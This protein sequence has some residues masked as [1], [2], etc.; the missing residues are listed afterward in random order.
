MRLVKWGLFF[1]V[2]IAI[3][4]ISAIKWLESVTLTP[5]SL[6]QPVVLQVKAGDTMGTVV[7]KLSS[8]GILQHGEALWF[9]I[10]ITDTAQKIHVGEYQLEPGITPLAL[11]EKLTLGEVIVY[12][13]TVV[14]GMRF[15]DV[16]E[17]LVENSSVKSTLQG[18][19]EKELMKLIGI[20]QQYTV[21][22]GWFFPD[23]YQ[24]T[25]GE[26]DLSIL[27]RGYQKMHSTL[28]KLWKDRESGLPLNSPYEA[29]ILA[30][31]IE[32]ETGVVQER[33]QIAGVFIRRLQRGM[34]LQ[35]DPTV[36]YGMGDAYI[37]KIKRQDL[38]KDTPYNTYTRHGLTPSPIALPGE[39]AIYAALHPQQG[40]TLFF[41][42]KGDGTHH[43]S[44]TLEEHQAAVRRYQVNR[45]K[46]YR[47]YPKR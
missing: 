13:F 42:A 17:K 1:I 20:P 10:R 35:T 47:S 25:K 46:D 2:L 33:E 32:K 40:D 14:E 45:K 43:F 31:I 7:T 44:V 21:A 12:Q 27:R 39:G 3:L 38:K 19:S 30:S 18:K 8:D 22:E 16:L 26:T 28:N 23:T 34:R 4:S 9:W 36:I 15:T 6:S 41:V 11:I 37:G 5:L 24:I 29:L